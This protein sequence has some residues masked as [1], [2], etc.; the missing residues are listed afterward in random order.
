MPLFTVAAKERGEDVA[1]A[2]AING[3]FRK[4]RAQNDGGARC[5]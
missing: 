3:A 4:S 2:S 5:V 1:A